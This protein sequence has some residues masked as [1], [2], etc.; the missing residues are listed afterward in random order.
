[1]ALDDTKSGRLTFLAIVGIIAAIIMGTLRLPFYWYILLFAALCM[2]DYLL[3]Y[4]S[5]AA[6]RPAPY[7]PGQSRTELPW[8]EQPGKYHIPLREL[9]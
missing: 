6:P 1:M 3:P 9:L 5:R 4:L 7:I 2:L 8:V